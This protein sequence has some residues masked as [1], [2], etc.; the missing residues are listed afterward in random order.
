MGRV[1]AGGRTMLRSLT[2]ILATVAALALFADVAAGGPLT[3]D[4]QRV[5][6]Q[7]KAANPGEAFPIP[8]PRGPDA[9]APAVPVP[10]LGD[11][12]S[13]Q[14]GEC[15]GNSTYS[16]FVSRRDDGD[17]APT[18]STYVDCFSLFVMTTCQLNLWG[19]Q[20]STVGYVPLDTKGFGI[21]VPGLGCN[22]TASFDPDVLDSKSYYGDWRYSFT[23]FDGKVWAPSPD[24]PPVFCTRGFGTPTAVCAN[25]KFWGWYEYGSFLIY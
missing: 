8:N 10:G 9:D 19:L 1:P 16:A 15:H 22:G 11:P 3:P 13:T 4:Q 18:M 20:D 5:I 24:P 2:A 17:F 25:E 12:L 14:S 23:R 6:A 21:G 7:W